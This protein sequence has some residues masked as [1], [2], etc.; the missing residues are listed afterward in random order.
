MPQSTAAAPVIE[1]S[2][3]TASAPTTPAVVR[4]DAS[5]TEAQ[6]GLIGSASDGG[7]LLCLG[8]SGKHEETGPY[9]VG[10]GRYTKDEAC[11]PSIAKTG[12]TAEGRALVFES[13][14]WAAWTT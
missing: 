14:A 3:T 1:P 9:N 5:C 7:T 2:T 4:K 10:T 11:D 13:G 8:K 12:R 6:A